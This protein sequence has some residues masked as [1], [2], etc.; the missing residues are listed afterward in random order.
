LVDGFGLCGVEGVFRNSCE[1]ILELLKNSR[2]QIMTIFEVLLYDPLH[3][4]CISPRK[5]YLLQNVDNEDDSILDGSNSNS[6]NSDD[7]LAPLNKS[8]LG[9]TFI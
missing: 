5:A 8:N 7:L 1:T 3:N 6:S 2:E 4:W 9:K